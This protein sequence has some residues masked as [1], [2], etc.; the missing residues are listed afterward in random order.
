M[1]D[2]RTPTWLIQLRFFLLCSPVGIVLAIILAPFA[3]PVLAGFS[4]GVF[5]FWHGSRLFTNCFVWLLDPEGYTALRQQG[6]D[7]FYGSL[8][9]PLNNDTESVRIYGR[10][11]NSNCPECDEPVFLQ[12]NVTTICPA[13]QSQWHDNHWWKWTGTRWVLV[14]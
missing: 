7:P 6:C 9:S 12:T 3:L 14:E 1:S 8:G 2:D 11:I 5:L 13:C 4:I 10:D